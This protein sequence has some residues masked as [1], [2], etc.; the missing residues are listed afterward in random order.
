MSGRFRNC[1]FGRKGRV[2]DSGGEE[3][4]RDKATKKEVWKDLA[5]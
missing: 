5:W 2:G 4:G 3:K 1:R